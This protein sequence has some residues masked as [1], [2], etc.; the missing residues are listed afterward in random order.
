MISK[1]VIGIYMQVAYSYAPM[2]WVG[3]SSPVVGFFAG[4][5]FADGL[6]AGK[7]FASTWAKR[8]APILVCWSLNDALN[9]KT[10]VD[11][12]HKHV[13]SHQTCH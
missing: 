12:C 1:N 6:I 9:S 2:L 7:L 3:E 8:C 5:P 4:W 11:G 13:K 10:R